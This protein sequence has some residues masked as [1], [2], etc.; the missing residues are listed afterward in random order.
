MADAG[1]RGGFR[2]G[3]EAAGWGLAAIGRTLVVLQAV[4]QRAAVWRWVRAS[5]SL[6][7]E[8]R[9]RCTKPT[10]ANSADLRPCRPRLVVAGL[11]AEPF[12]VGAAGHV[13]WQD[14]LE[15]LA[16]APV[17]TLADALL[18]AAAAHGLRRVGV[19]TPFEPGG[20]AR[21]NT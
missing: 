5:P 15:R 7:C 12:R 17:V 10:N 9:P 1:G 4:L 20:N 6:Q 2:S 8:R 21:G 13:A 11:S 19:L 18:A 3:L 16:D 14:D